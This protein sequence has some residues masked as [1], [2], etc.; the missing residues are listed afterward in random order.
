MERI[1][2]VREGDCENSKETVSP[3]FY[4]RF[5]LDVESYWADEA[6][7]K[8][9]PKER[10]LAMLKQRLHSLSFDPCIGNR[11]GFSK[12]AAQS[13]FDGRVDLSCSEQLVRL[14]F[15]VE[16]QLQRVKDDIE[17]LKSSSSRDNFNVSRKNL[18]L[19]SVLPRAKIDRKLVEI[20]GKVDG[21]KALLDF[22]FDQISDMFDLVK[23][24]VCEL[25][26]EHELQKE[27]GGVV[28]Q[29]YVRGLQDEFETRLYEQRGLIN[30]LNLY[31]EEKVSELTSM[32]EELDA[33][34]KSPMKLEEFIIHSN[35]TQE[36]F[37][38]VSITKWRDRLL[39]PL[40]DE[41]G[42]GT[43]LI[44]KSASAREVVLDY[45]DL[46]ILKHMKKEEVAI[47]FRTEMTKVRRQH[48]LAL[49]EKTEELFRV[50][51]EFLKEKRLLFFRKDKEIEFLRKVISDVVS[52]LDEI[53]LKK[54]NAPVN[55]NDNDEVCRL[56]GK[57]DSLV[58]DNQCLRGSLADKRKE[59]KHLLSQVSDAAR[60]MSIYSLSEAKLRKQIKKLKGDLEDQ[61]IEVSIRDDLHQVFLR[62]L[63]D[64]C[65]SNIEDLKIQSDVR[66][67]EFDLLHHEINKLSDEVEKQEIQIGDLRTES[68]LW[69]R[70]F[71]ESLQQIRKYEA[72]VDTL[73]QKLNSASNALED[74]KKDNCIL[75]TII[76]ENEKALLSSVTREKDQEKR[77][78]SIVMLIRELSKVCTDAENKMV[79]KVQRFEDRLENLSHQCNSVVEQANLLNKKGLW[80]KEM[81]EIRCSDLQKAEAEVNLL[82]DKV[83]TLSSLLEK[84]HIALGHYPTLSQHYPGLLDSFV[85]TC[86]LVTSLKS[87]QKKE[88]KDTK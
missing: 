25:Q 35:N 11:L 8:V 7:E 49:Q 53:L 1:Q 17:D 73:N 6:A 3:A 57:I 32:R 86:K 75:S 78:K 72:E 69:K 65:R 61:Q 40:H 54:L 19:Q 34:Y 68:D 36:C 44:E 13:L 85:R 14:R 66:Q 64:D 47:Y 52:K 30:S 80:Y 42:N 83:D 46:P 51:R 41:N 4:E 24:S 21:L 27:V 37:E 67:A 9:T 87:N 28:I 63:I 71:D 5:F 31:R 12:G 18:G 74:K 16:E 26:W 55:S 29:N 10:D 81:L 56:K 33:V 20:D 60:K 45:A 82:G 88:R 76:E 59:V 15:A 58:F 43:P 23:I 84:I 62:E 50:K 77:L 70:R 39:L 2:S 79:E 48:E 38:D 22:G